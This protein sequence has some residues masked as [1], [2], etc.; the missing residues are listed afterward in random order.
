MRNTYQKIQ[1]KSVEIRNWMK[2]VWMK[3][4]QSTFMRANLQK[5]VD[6]F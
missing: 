6:D 5:D 2:Q 3:G 4:K 1:I